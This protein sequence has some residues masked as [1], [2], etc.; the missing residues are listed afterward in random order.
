MELKLEQ[1]KEERNRL[2]ELERTREREI[3]ELAKLQK[4][5]EKEIVY[6][7]TSMEEKKERK[8]VADV[9]LNVFLELPNI[10]FK[11]KEQARKEKR[12]KTMINNAVN[13]QNL[14]NSLNRNQQQR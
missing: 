6:I 3:K 13:R 5:K 10:Y 9:F 1:A 7:N 2:R 14:L 8:T 12:I 4:K 11:A